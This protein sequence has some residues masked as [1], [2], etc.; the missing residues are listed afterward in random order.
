MHFYHSLYMIVFKLIPET[1]IFFPC[2]IPV[3]RNPQSE[4]RFWFP[5]NLLDVRA[6]RDI[7]FKQIH[8]FN[9]LSASCI[10]YNKSTF[11]CQ[12]PEMLK[13]YCL[14]CTVIEFVQMNPITPKNEMKKRK[15]LY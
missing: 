14:F 11:E 9:V 2:L 4:T 13:T 8:P 12:S 15:E 5:I 7:G 6:R 1:E 3:Y 10:L